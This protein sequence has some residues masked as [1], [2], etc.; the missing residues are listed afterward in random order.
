MVSLYYNSAWQA[1]IVHF[2]VAGGPWQDVRTTRTE[3]HFWHSAN[4]PAVPVAFVLTDGQ[5][6]WDNPSPQCVSA[7]HRNYYVEKPGRYA[8]YHGNLIAI[9][10]TAPRLLLI[11]D[12]DGTLAQEHDPTAAAASAR[13][14]Q[15]WLQRHYFN[16]SK[17]VYSSGRSL[18]EFLQ[19]RRSGID[20]LDPDLYIGEVGSDAYVMRS[21]NGRYEVSEDYRT[22]FPGVN[23][24]TALVSQVLDSRFPWLTKPHNTGN[25]RLTTYRVARIEDLTQHLSELREFLERR[26]NWTVGDKEIRCFMHISGSGSHRYLDF[27]SDHKGKRAGVQYCRRTLGFS[28]DETLVAGDSGNDLTMFKGPERGVIPANRQEEMDRWLHKKDRGTNKY[29]S[30]CSFA[31]AIVEALT[32]F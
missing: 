23:W 19:L 16:G 3:R 5:N 27:T 11:T 20:L 9:D 18:E 4:V 17:L 31:D 22:A 1:P 7:V 24:D 8:V 14:A 26:E 13:F 2:S 21:D 10:E 32:R 25:T 6:R 28:A 29:V 12:L 30:Q 15:F